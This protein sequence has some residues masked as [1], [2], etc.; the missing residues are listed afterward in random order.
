M[1][2]PQPVRTI[3]TNFSGLQGLKQVPLGLMLSVIS[4]WASA[5][6]GPAKDIIFPVG[7]AILFFYI[8]QVVN[9]FYKRAFGTV[10]PTF[11]QRL[12]EAARVLV[13]AAAAL[14]AFYVDVAIMPSISMVGLVFGVAILAEYFRISR[15]TNNNEMKY[16]PAAALF[17]F[18]LSSAPILGFN[19]WDPMG[20]KALILGICTVAGI[21][22]TI[23]GMLTHISLENLLFLTG[24]M[25]NE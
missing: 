15:K 20:F 2:N 19:W 7:C 6:T 4:L 21:A 3:T 1:D 14:T 22:F 18:V 17:I 9:N 16:Y 5:Q 8:Y 13:G 25:T 10:I 11:K 24:E 12:L 23:I